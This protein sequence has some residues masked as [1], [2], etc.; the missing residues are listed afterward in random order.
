MGCRG[1]I[2]IEPRTRASGARLLLAQPNHGWI[3]WARNAML[4]LIGHAANMS[5]HARGSSVPRAARLPTQ[6]ACCGTEHGV[7]CTVHEYSPATCQVAQTW[8]MPRGSPRMPS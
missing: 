4:G 5:R 8:G 7:Y 6:G 1:C 2:H 3:P